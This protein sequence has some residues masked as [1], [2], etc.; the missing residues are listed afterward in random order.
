MKESSYE[1]I[2]SYPA[3]STP[4]TRCADSCGEACDVE[5]V[6][7]DSV[8]TARDALPHPERRERLVAVFAALANPTRLSI[9]VALTSCLDG[10]RSE[11]CVCDLMAVTGASQ[12]LTSHQ[13]GVLRDAG[14]VTS[15]REGRLVFHRLVDETTRRILENALRALPES[16]S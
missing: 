7:A 9:L 16:R 1:K 2:A 5:A 15:R 3:V 8:A 6:H 14:L 4:P 10:P 12:S 13:L 11:L